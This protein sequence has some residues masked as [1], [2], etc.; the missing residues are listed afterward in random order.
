MKKVTLLLLFAL[1][2]SSCN[3]ESFI[4]D[5]SPGKVIRS[6]QYDL[7]VSN[8]SRLIYVYKNGGGVE[9]VFIEDNIIQSNPNIPFW[10]AAVMA[11]SYQFVNF[12][13]KGDRYYYLNAAGEL[14]Y[15]FDGNAG[16]K[17]SSLTMK[18]TSLQNIITPDGL[19]FNENISA[20]GWGIDRIGDGYYFSGNRNTVERITTR[21]GLTDGM[22]PIDDSSPVDNFSEG[23]CQSNPG[24]CVDTPYTWVTRSLLMQDKKHVLGIA[25]KMVV[26]SGMARLIP[27]YVFRLSDTTAEKRL[28]AGLTNDQLTYVEDIVKIDSQGRMKLFRTPQMLAWAHRNASTVNYFGIKFS[29]LSLNVFGSFTGTHNTHS[30]ASSYLDD[31]LSQDYV[32]PLL[33]YNAGGVNQIHFYDGTQWRQSPQL[34]AHLVAMDA[35]HIAIRKNKNNPGWDIK[36]FLGGM[37]NLIWCNEDLTSCTNYFTSSSAAETSFITDSGTFVH[38][39][40]QIV[41]YEMGSPVK[42]LVFSDA[43]GSD[44]LAGIFLFR[45]GRFASVRYSNAYV[46]KI[47]LL[48]KDLKVVDSV[49]HGN[50]ASNAWVTPEEE[51]FIIAYQKLL[52]VTGSWY[53]LKN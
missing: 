13:Q 19:Y 23:H 21:L 30:T 3:K 38:T 52:N 27:Y 42:T 8:N 49:F 10:D 29:D 11:E 7:Q 33:K 36:F 48:D 28:I 34:N 31:D 44:Y 45:E 20:Y 9:G 18:N 2:V 25:S 37:S 24:S 5:I 32:Y 53:V 41:K 1:I 35:N 15:T 47:Y 39:P 22:M 50:V 6:G 46:G 51:K 16:T 12:A 14:F 26:I 4:T 40:T 17:I 43:I